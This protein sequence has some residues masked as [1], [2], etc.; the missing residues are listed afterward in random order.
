MCWADIG[1][2]FD[3]LAPHIGVR[4]LGIGHERDKRI[5]LS[6]CGARLHQYKAGEE[7]EEPGQTRDL[8]EFESYLAKASA[9]SFAALKARC[10]SGARPSEAMRISRAAAVVPPGEVTCSRNSAAEAAG[11]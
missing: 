7:R 9:R 10:M 6:R 4:T 2:R 5:F 11:V 8:H 1:Q 3:I